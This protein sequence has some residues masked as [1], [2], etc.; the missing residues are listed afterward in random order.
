MHES[1]NVTPA[2]EKNEEVKKTD[3]ENIKQPLT[4]DQDQQHY[5]NELYYDYLQSKG[6]D[7]TKGEAY[8]NAY[9]GTMLK[10]WLQKGSLTNI[11]DLNNIAGSKDK[12][13]QF[14]DKQTFTFGPLSNQTQA[15]NKETVTTL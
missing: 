7:I 6:Y 10:Q 11:L 2:E 13:Y 8:N 9:Y 14:L 15:E 12:F 4:L 1:N 3:V 5:V